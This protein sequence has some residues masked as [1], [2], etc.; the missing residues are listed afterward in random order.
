MRLHFSICFFIFS[1]TL[2]KL[3]F[4]FGSVMRLPFIYL[5]HSVKWPFTFFAPDKMH[6][7]V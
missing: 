1:K 5:F 7:L 4:L 3:Y 6:G 2:F